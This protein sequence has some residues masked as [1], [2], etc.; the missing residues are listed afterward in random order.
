[1]DFNMYF[2][3]TLLSLISDLLGTQ[4]L[5]KTPGIYQ[6]DFESLPLDPHFI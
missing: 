4:S 1:M 2:R 3:G 6:G 5:R